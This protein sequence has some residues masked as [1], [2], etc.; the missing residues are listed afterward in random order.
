VPRK[1]LFF[2]KQIPACGRQTSLRLAPAKVRR[3][4][5]SGTPFAMTLDFPF[6]RI[7]KPRH[8]GY[9]HLRRYEGNGKFN[10]A[11]GTPALLKSSSRPDCQSS[12]MDSGNYIFLLLNL[13]SS[14][15]RRA[16]C[17]R[18]WVG[19]QGWRSHFDAVSHSRDQSIEAATF[20]QRSVHAR[21]SQ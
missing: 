15:S 14:P 7:V 8:H 10:R 20:R 9:T 16:S 5:I 17:G 6:W 4:S 1:P 19:S 3:E 11:G 2:E 21:H 18:H 13:R 12:Q